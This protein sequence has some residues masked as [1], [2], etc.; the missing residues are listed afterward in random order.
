MRKSDEIKRKKAPGAAGEAR[1]MVFD[2]YLGRMHINTKIIL[3]PKNPVTCKYCR[4]F[5]DDFI[6]RNLFGLIL[7][8]DEAN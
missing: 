5:V 8:S 1:I 2:L 3:N 7:K 4:T 6:V